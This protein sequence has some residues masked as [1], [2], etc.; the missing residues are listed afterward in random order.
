MLDLYAHG[1][2]ATGD[3]NAM[4]GFLRRMELIEGALDKMET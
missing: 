1:T 4:P 3:H 2:D